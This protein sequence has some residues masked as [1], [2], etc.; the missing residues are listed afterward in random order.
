[1]LPAIVPTFVGRI[2]R[3]ELS[4]Q[5]SVGLGE[6][7]RLRGEQAIGSGLELDGE[8]IQL[9]AFTSEDSGRRAFS[10]ITRPSARR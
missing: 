10:R 6:D 7:L 1:M 9:S 5:P 2:D 4:R 8:L 3:A